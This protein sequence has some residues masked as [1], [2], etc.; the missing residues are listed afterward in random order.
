M[1]AYATVLDLCPA[2][3]WQ[4][5]PEFNTRVVTLRNGQERRNANWAQVRHRFVLPFQ[6][7]ASADYL[8]ELKAAFLS[9]LGQTH[10]FLVKDH[11]DFQAV[12][13]SLG[14]APAGTT[15]VQLQKVSTFG[16]ATYTRTITKPRSGTVTVYQ[17]GV[18][19]SGTYSTTTGLFTPSTAWT[20]GEALTADFEFY[21]PVRFASD[22][23]PMTIDN[24]SGANYVMNGS[25]ELVEVF[26]E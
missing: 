12:A 18:A 2:Y 17:A 10:S 19:K 21:V 24:R 25:I 16:A 9:V 22:L 7:I 3:G 14:N 26:G 8:V 11:S 20:E 4:G 5:G 1:T 13:A 6:N 15:A 23:L